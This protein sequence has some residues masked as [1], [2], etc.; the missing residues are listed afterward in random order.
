MSVM[1]RV[2]EQGLIF[3]GAMGSMLINAGLKGGESPEAW[4]LERPDEISRVHRKY[5]NAGAEVLTTATFGSNSIKLGKADMA[6]QMELI[7]STAGDLARRIAG[8]DCFVAGNL[9]PTGELLSP[10]GMLTADKAKECFAAQAKVL[11][12]SG[13]DLFLVQTFYDLQELLA[14]VEGVRSVSGLP[15]FTTM[16]FQK[17]KTGFVT[18]MGNRVGE[19]MKQLLNAG[20]NVVGANCSISS[21]AMVQLAKEIRGTTSEP[22]MAQPNAGAPQLDNGIAVYD[23]SPEI[24]AENIAQIKALKVEAV[25]G[26]CGTT[27]EHIHA[28]ANLLR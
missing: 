17:K 3:D 19:S 1:S 20:A 24:F 22:I 21:S 15:I 25:G 13:V 10:A 11:T 14:A 27:P 4:L 16:S 7:N 9:G 28:M 26:C 5:K 12:D 8:N 18:I 2:K 23:E 6:H